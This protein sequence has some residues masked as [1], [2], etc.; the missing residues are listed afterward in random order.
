MAE[1]IRWGILGTGWIAHQQTTDLLGNGF[2]VTAVGSR[3]QASADAFAAEFGIPAAHGSYE[4]L[5]AD[6]TVD[7]DGDFVLHHLGQP[8]WVRV[9]T[10]QPAVE[11]MARVAHDVH[12]RRATAV[13]IGLLNRDN[14]WVRWTLRERT[15]WQTLLLPASPFVPSH[16]DEMLDRRGSAAGV[17]TR[18]ANPVRGE[19]GVLDPARDE[20]GVSQDG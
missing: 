20:C 13:E 7:D 10:D 9:R 1:K 15:V 19:V 2:T 4:A 12:S 17:Y 11:I 5:V 16:L 18:C 14:L 8:V 3:T 6:P